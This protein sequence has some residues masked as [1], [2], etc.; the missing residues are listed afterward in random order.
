MTLIPILNSVIMHFTVGKCC[1]KLIWEKL[2]D[3]EVYNV[4][5]HNTETNSVLLCLIIRFLYIPLGS[6]EY[7]ITI[8][9]Y[10]VPSTLISALIYFTIHSLIYAFIANHLSSI[11]EILQRKSWTWMNSSEKMEFLFFIG[12]ITSTILIFIYLNIWIN[13][14]VK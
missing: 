10:G 13:R 3:Y 8:L 4:L 2:Y 7:I 11:S 5:I 1:T 9:E 6:K 12:I 14:K